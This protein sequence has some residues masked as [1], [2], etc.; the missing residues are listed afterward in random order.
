MATIW[1][2]DD[3]KSE[4][5]STTEPAPAA[6]R[7]RKDKPSDAEPAPIEKTQKDKESKE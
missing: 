4:Q 5:A 7:P 1:I 2:R 6:R 3:L